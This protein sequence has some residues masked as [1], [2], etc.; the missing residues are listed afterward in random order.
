MDPVVVAFF[1]SYIL[2]AGY[3]L[4]NI[5]VAVLL[6]E[7]VRVSCRQRL[8]SLSETHACDGSGHTMHGA[9]AAPQIVQSRSADLLG[10]CV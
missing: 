5:I 4:L 1:V 8:Q 3:F 9:G 2:L 6:D 7:F 10:L